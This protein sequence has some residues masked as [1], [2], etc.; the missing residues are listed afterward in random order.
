M[1]LGEINRMTHKYIIT[2][3]FIFLTA[4]IFASNKDSLKLASK[5]LG[6][7]IQGDTVNGFQLKLSYRN[8]DS[9]FLVDSIIYSGIRKVLTTTTWN[10]DRTFSINASYLRDK[11]SIYFKYLVNDSTFDINTFLDG[12]K[13]SK[14]TVP[15]MVQNTIKYGGDSTL[16]IHYWMNYKSKAYVLTSIG[17]TMEFP[18]RNKKIYRINCNQ[19]N[20]TLEYI[21]QKSNDK[22]VTFYYRYDYKSKL[23]VTH[24]STNSHPPCEKIIDFKIQWRKMNINNIEYINEIIEKSYEKKDYNSC[25]YYSIKRKKKL[26]MYLMPDNYGRASGTVKIT[27]KS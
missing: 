21:F 27:Y 14:D 13:D 12:L 25:H 19:K 23:I 6:F 11:V 15:R 26:Y 4:N 5:E 8:K 7:N 3:I 9:T 24:D 1:T 20:D 17:T 16:T 18:N 2:S 22:W 10:K